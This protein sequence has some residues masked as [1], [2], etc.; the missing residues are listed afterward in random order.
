V[1]EKNVHDNTVS[2]Y[3][4]AEDAVLVPHE[5]MVR[6]KELAARLAEAQQKILAA[7]APWWRNPTPLSVAVAA[8]ALTI[9]GNI[10]AALYT[11]YNSLA[12]EKEKNKAA[13][14]V[15]AVSTSDP[16]TARRNVLFF[17]ESGFFEGQSEKI[18][19]ALEKFLPV[20]PSNTGNAPSLPV[21]ADEYEKDFWQAKLRP[22]VVATLDKIVERIIG[23]KDRFEVVARQTHCPWYIIAVLSHREGNL[24]FAVYLG[25]GDPWKLVTTHAP[26]GRG[27]FSSWEDGA[28]DAIKFF[29]LDGT[30][31]LPLGQLL[32][33]MEGFNGFG[34]RVYGIFSPYLWS[35]TDLYT[36][37][38]Y[39]SERNFDPNVI[40]A[41]IGIVGLLRRM[42]ELGKI[43]LDTSK[44]VV[45]RP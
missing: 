44:Q 12:V 31:N 5:G 37:G 21:S 19:Q 36:K 42:H 29:Q 45:A 43:E 41:Q 26:A 38:K 32:Q 2:E 39:I 30:D 20:L 15:Q 28:V 35:S 11:G 8:G 1:T 13:L 4:D 7:R 10:G 17:V 14:I 22:D 3:R 18:K 40:D 27:P 6:R 9:L 25:N 23:A 34:Y 16:A 24:S 33:R